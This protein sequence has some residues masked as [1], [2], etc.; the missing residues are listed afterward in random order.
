MNCLLHHFASPL[1]YAQDDATWAV[2]RLSPQLTIPRLSSFVYRSA[3]TESPRM[4]A[5]LTALARCAAQIGVRVSEDQS[6]QSLLD[7]SLAALELVLHR[8]ATEPVERVIDVASYLAAL[9]SASAWQ[10][11]VALHEQGYFD[12]CDDPR[13][14]YYLHELYDGRREHGLLAVGDR[15]WYLSGLALTA[16]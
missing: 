6:F 9:G 5:T 11:I 2:S 16:Q 10:R 3:S 13:D 12:T 15:N 1:P 4:D 8:E 7:Q 14:I